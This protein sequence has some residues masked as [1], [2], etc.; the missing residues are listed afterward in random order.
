MSKTLDQY[1]KEN[2]KFLTL[3][4][5]EKFE[6][7]YVAYRIVP[8]SFDPEKETIVYK[9]K[10]KTGEFTY[11]QSAS[12]YCAKMFGKLKEGDAVKVTRHG[13]GMKTKYLI[14]S[15]ALQA[16]VVGESDLQPDDGADL[17]F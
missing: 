1:A 7:Y 15:P 17:P 11:L 3:G 6:G 13:I 9:L 12:T 10:H 4:D 14:E 2:S 5:G 8:N 16:G